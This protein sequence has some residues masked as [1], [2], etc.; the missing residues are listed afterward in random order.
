MTRIR[1]SQPDLAP[2]S[3][4]RPP[5][6]AGPD[7]D[8]VVGSVR[9]PARAPA[10]R[11]LGPYVSIARPDHWFKNVFMALGILLAYFYHPELLR[12]N[13]LWQ[14]LWAVAATCLIASSNYVLNEI[15]D[16]PT[17]R[18]H[19]VKRY[20]PIPSGQVW[21]PLAYAE[22][23][24]LGVLGLVM[25]ALLN[26]AF[27]ASGLL[28]LVMGVIYNV[29]PVRSKELPYVDV[30]SESINNP[31]RLLLGWFALAPLEFPPVSLLI[32]YWMIGAFFMASKRFAEYRSIADPAAAGAYRSSFRHYDEQ[33]LLIS[34]F[35]YT[36][37]FALFLG[38][39]IIRY[40]LELILIFPL[41]AG[42]VCHYLQIAFKPNSAA[43]N[44]ERLYRER[45][46]MV[47]LVICVIAFIGLMFVNIPVLYDWFNVQPSTVS[48][49]W[50]F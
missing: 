9:V 36:T 20:R 14:I 23:I 13:T 43:Q 26:W 27:F 37:T 18:S 17:D 25:A 19:P 30:L 35:F 32:A 7:A 47:Y 11:G 49:L 24:F 42:F 45:G 40:H 41:V 34:M 2:A 50:K 33:K 8:R 22:W 10:A 4:D 3:V 28:L 15:L 44:P 46:L 6:A 21:L 29:P 39:F 5:V 31:I 1:E 12:Q 16:A 48:P 38:V